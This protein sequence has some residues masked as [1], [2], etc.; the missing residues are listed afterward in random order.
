MKTVREVPSNTTYNWYDELKF[1][2][3]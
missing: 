1:F 2:E 3:R